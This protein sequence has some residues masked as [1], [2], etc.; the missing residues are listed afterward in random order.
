MAEQEKTELATPR[1]REEIRKRGQ[2]VKSADMN[3]AIGL[4]AC[5]FTL[6]IAGPH[7]AAGLRELAEG[8]FRG[9][10]TLEL[11]PGGVR[12]LF[13]GFLGKSALVLAPVLMAAAAAGLVANVAQCGFLISSTPVTPDLS[14]V[15]P[16]TGFQRLLSVRAFAELAKGIG[17][18]I[19]VGAV[20]YF[21]LRGHY[22]TV[23][24]LPAMDR[25]TVI[26]TLAT[27]GW[28]LMLRAAVALLVIAVLDY[29]FQRAQFEKSIKMTRQEVKEE[30]R[31]TEGDPLVKSRVRHRQ[32]EMARARM[33]AEVAR[34][35]VVV[36]NPVH[37]AIAV[38]YEPA[39]ME[40]PTVL[41]KGQ[42]LIAERIKEAAR[43]HGVPIVEN[44]PVAQLLF[45]LGEIGEQIPAALYQAMAEII[46]YV[47]RLSGRAQD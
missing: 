26:A 46:A 47:Y 1:K 2:V 24:M 35:T 44:P 8:A 39:E 30:F 29:M 4:I 22:Q 31:R 40:A 32:R 38:R 33:I 19:V 15:N 34:A 17:K 14:R 7:L 10:A 16:I 37:L 5:L 3:A 25:S 20:S 11:T 21:Y 23:V 13:A 36:T 6:K 42:R 43:E 28:G 41:A 9:A 18:L 27:L 45:K 12:A